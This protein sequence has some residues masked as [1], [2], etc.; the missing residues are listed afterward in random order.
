MALTAFSNLVSRKVITSCMIMSS[1]FLTG[2]AST[3]VDTA[4]K[5]VPVQ[6]FKKNAQPKPVQLSF[7]FQ[8]NGA[9]NATATTFLKDKV[10]EQIKASGLFSSVELTPVAGAN[11]L[12][13]TIN[14]IPITKDAAAQ[15]FVTGLTF[16]LAGSAVTDGY[17]STMRYLPVGQTEFI[18]TTAK[19][20]IHTTLGNA[21]PPAGAKKSADGPDAIFTMT[22]EIISNNLRDLA[23]NPNFK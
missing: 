18:V 16:G 12:S 5:E 14:N 1:I 6:E 17:V 20:A 22:R 15:G 2:C 7:D 4:T 8:T 23:A 10:T 11:M 21:S 3:Y 9:P 13:V 19:H